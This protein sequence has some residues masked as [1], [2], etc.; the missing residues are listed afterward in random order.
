[1]YAVDSNYARVE[2][3]KIPDAPVPPTGCP[4]DPAACPPPPGCPTDAAKCPPPPTCPAEPTKCPPPP[5]CPADPTKCVKS[6]T[7]ARPISKLAKLATRIAVRRAPRLIRGTAR[8]DVKVTRVRVSIVRKASKKRC[9]ALTTKGTWQKYKPKKNTCAP[10]FNLTA[11][12]TTKWTLTL[13]KRLGRG[14]YT[15]ASQAADSKP[16]TELAPTAKAGNQRTITV[17]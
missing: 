1:M 12:G 7:D 16:Q 11:K 5:G 17:R 6:P 2:A 3:F 8:D 9:L 4:A 13:K 15:I 10:H 14:A